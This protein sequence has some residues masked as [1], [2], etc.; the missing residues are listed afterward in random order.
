[1]KKLIV[2]L[3]AWTLAGCATR[4]QVDPFSRLSQN[5]AKAVLVGA[6]I[7]PFE[8]DPK[9]ARFK[10]Y[11]RI[12]NP[13]TVAKL[14][15]LMRQAKSKPDFPF[16]GILSYQRFVDARGHLLAETH[17]VNFDNS[18]VVSDMADP[19]NGF[20]AMVRSKVFCRTIYDLM[21]QN[22]PEKI[23]AQRR[24]YREWNR[25]LETLLFEGRDVEETAQ[26]GS[27]TVR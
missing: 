11:F 14:T 4:L 1:M 8:P 7:N 17:I 20:C 26:Q 25:K 6:I 13:E 23:E 15:D 9:K 19:G 3:A 24:T 16:I 22:C 10:T 2:I 12:E 5:A 18:V 21:L 27:G